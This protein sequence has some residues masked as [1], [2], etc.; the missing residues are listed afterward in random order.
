MTDDEEMSP[1]DGFNNLSFRAK[2]K[3]K[4]REK[5]NL[6]AKRK[7][8]YERIKEEILEEKQENNK[9]FLEDIVI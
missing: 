3:L 1:Q 9:Y 8:L 5:Q 7:K 4:K 2:R 6:K